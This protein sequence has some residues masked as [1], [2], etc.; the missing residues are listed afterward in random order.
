MSSFLFHK[1]TGAEA[2]RADQSECTYLRPGVLAAMAPGSAGPS[3]RL[4]TIGPVK[5]VSNS[6]TLFDH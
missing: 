3:R 6:S 2:S 1:H 4:T 5:S